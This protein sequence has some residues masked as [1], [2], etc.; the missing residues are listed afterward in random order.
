MDVGWDLRASMLM[1]FMG[2][3]ALTEAWIAHL[4]ICKLAMSLQ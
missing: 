4:S 3:R 1:A 2:Q